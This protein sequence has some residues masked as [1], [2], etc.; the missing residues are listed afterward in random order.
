MR[1]L[2]LLLFNLTLGT[3]F[4]QAQTTIHWEPEIIVADGATYGN[5]RP[6]ISLTRNDIP[7]VVMGKGAQGKLFLA[8]G[9]GAGFDAPVALLPDNFDTYLASWT[10]PDLASTKDT[11][12]VV[13]KQMPLEDGKIY[14]VRSVDGG[15]TFT[16]TIRVDN[17][18]SGVAWLPAMDIDENGNPSIIYMIHDASWSNPRYAVSHSFDQGLSYAPL[19][20]VGSS[21]PDEACDCCP[22]EYVINGQEH[23]LLFRNNA[24]NVRDIYA[25]YSN[26]DGNTFPYFENVDQLNW[27]VNSCPS[28]GPHG[29]FSN[30]NLYTTYTSKAS[31]FNRIYVS[32]SSTSPTLSMGTRI[33]MTAPLNSNG[34]QNYPRISGNNDTLTLVWQESDP[35]NPEI[36]VSFTT[37]GDLSQ[38][39][40]SKQQVNSNSTGSQT[41][42]DI[43]YSNGIIH[44]VYQ[45][46]PTGSVIYRKGH[47]GNLSID[48]D[49][50]NSVDI[51]P[52][53]ISEG[54]FA[55]NKSLNETE[56][57]VF[58]IDGRNED[59]TIGHEGDLTTVQLKNPQ[60]GIYLLQLQLQNQIK[61]IRFNSN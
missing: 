55:I 28:T 44:V 3:F 22:A 47:L 36:F 25:N 57:K 9:N 17:H 20:D 1:P 4:T 43:V 39:T 49:E 34:I 41:N 50:V 32:K 53:P 48:M 15:L 19:I 61:I 33:E 13:F 21:N 51:F 6:R 37:T 29:V 45:D 7:V 26:D 46:N 27:S 8:R 12:I 59:I 38:L 11:V 23:A 16:D 54:R 35:S 2:L 60:K 14:A 30:G 42:P 18:D 31:G 10:G 40:T 24:N 52:N 58:S 5:I 56:I